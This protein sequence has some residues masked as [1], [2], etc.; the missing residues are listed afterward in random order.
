MCQV[1][2]QTSY[3]FSAFNPDSCLSWVRLLLPF[4]GGPETETQLVEEP[5]FGPRHPESTALTTT[6]LQRNKWV[7]KGMGEP[8]KASP[9]DFGN[10][11]WYLAQLPGRSHN[12]S[13][14]HHLSCRT[15]RVWAEQPGT[16]S[17]CQGCSAGDPQTSSLARLLSTRPSQPSPEDSPF[18]PTPHCPSFQ[19]H[20]WH[21]L[22]IIHILSE[23]P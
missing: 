20:T 10:E 21:F 8:K 19:P 1:L 15:M 16:S 17:G 12:T 11:G 23:Q 13:F 18:P 4:H 9:E 6:L 5:R 7:N 14:T 22:D 2:F 3:I